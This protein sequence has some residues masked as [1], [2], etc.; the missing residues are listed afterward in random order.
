MILG[1]KKKEKTLNKIPLRDFYNKRNKIII[2]RNSRG[3]GDILNCRMLFKNFK[4]L[5]PDLHLTFA[6][7]PEYAGLIHDH[8]YVDAVVDS[9]KI[10][11]NDYMASYDISNCCIHYESSEMG[12]NKKHRAE[13]WANHCGIELKNHDMDLPFITK[14][15]IAEGYAT[16]KKF[17][18]ESGPNVFLSPVAYEKLRSLTL[19]QLVGTVKFLREKGL[20]V[21]SA[22][23]E[24]VQ[25]LNDLNIPV[26]IGKTLENWMSYIHAAD[27]VVTVD[28]SSFHYAG[29]IGK[30]LTGIFTHVDGKL[31]GKF[32][33]FILVQKHRNN[34]DWPCGGPCY[35][36]LYC[37]HPNCAEPVIGPNNQRSPF[38]LRPCLTELSLDE[39]KAGIE[40][41]L[42]K[43]NI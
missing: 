15:K 10:N 26:L 19:D 33:D 22:H 4:K 9:N 21:Y 13:I 5:M 1:I 34:G 8:P 17:K 20:F 12:N 32:Y 42:I 38:G 14:E 41:M 30:P 3:I 23:N 43:W 7:F 25:M 39:I 24:P 18:K 29:G 37:S 31:R 28:T 2:I 27:Y 6:C 40:K 11:K 36:Y 35:N 16:L